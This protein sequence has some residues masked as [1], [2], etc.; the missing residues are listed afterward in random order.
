M[1]DR[2]EM[3]DVHDW[4]EILDDEDGFVT[5]CRACSKETS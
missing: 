1:S 2:E 5:I 4:I 3:C